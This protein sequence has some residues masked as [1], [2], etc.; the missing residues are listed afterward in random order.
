MANVNWELEAKA[1]RRLLE[2][3]GREAEHEMT[4]HKAP[5]T[6]AIYAAAMTRGAAAFWGRWPDSSPKWRPECGDLAGPYRPGGWWWCVRGVEVYR[7]AAYQTKG[8][9]QAQCDAMNREAAEQVIG[10][11][12]TET[13]EGDVI[14]TIDDT[15]APAGGCVALMV[16]GAFVVPIPFGPALGLVGLYGFLFEPWEG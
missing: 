13:L 10:E 3:I 8:Q 15:P 9:A 1:L 7:A 12:R 5:G 4:G 11:L 14:A 16:L 2:L 6:A